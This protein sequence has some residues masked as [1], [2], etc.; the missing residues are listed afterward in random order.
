VLEKEVRATLAEEAIHSIRQSLI[1]GTSRVVFGEDN[2]QIAYIVNY[3]LSSIFAQRPRSSDTYL[4]SSKKALGRAI[5]LDVSLA[6]NLFL[7]K[8]PINKP[9][10]VTL[11]ITKI[12]RDAEFRIDH[13]RQLVTYITT[14]LSRENEIDANY[15][16]YPLF[17]QFAEAVVAHLTIEEA[18]PSPDEDEAT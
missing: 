3:K 13:H 1:D 14:T 2:E 8:L 6:T 10:I 16:D 17:E 9:I 12:R 4:S 15:I 7:S 18:A 5:C 11:D